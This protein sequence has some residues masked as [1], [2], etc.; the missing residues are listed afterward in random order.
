[1]NE[2]MN[3]RKGKKKKKKEKEKNRPALLTY[4]PNTKL[5]SMHNNLPTDMNKLLGQYG[6]VHLGFNFIFSLK[7]NNHTVHK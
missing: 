1:M 6:Y 3:E 5:L 7:C 4:K 2:W